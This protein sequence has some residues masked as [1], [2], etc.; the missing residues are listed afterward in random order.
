MN[1]LELPSQYVSEQPLLW[2]SL[3]V[4]LGVLIGLRIGRWLERSRSKAARVSVP[5]GNVGLEAGGATS[6][7]HESEPEQV[8]PELP[9]GELA[10]S[11]LPGMTSKQIKLLGG[12][13]VLS[14]TQLR[15]ATA[16]KKDREHLA[17]ELQL[18]DF[19]V[20]KW[21]KM[22]DFLS[23]DDMTPEVAE[24]LVVAGINSTKDLAS[25]NPESVAHKLQN[26]N[27]KEDRIDSVPT[28]Q[29]LEAWVAAIG[30]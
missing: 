8:E 20:N 18:E 30:S 14:V 26:L 1:F 12:Q 21:A 11:R 6:V 24:F 25:R 23:L 10:L 7:A 9:S 15:G 13:G 5:E 29:Q 17:D 2:L 3:A 4:V 16:S 19:V 27:E 22:A 28:R